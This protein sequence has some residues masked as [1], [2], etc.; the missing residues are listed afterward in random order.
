MSG[1]HNDAFLLY[2]FTKYI[3]QNGHTV[4]STPLWH[5][6]AMKA[7]SA[8][9]MFYCFL[10]RWCVTVFTDVEN[11]NN[12]LNT[13]AQDLSSVSSYSVYEPLSNDFRTVVQSSWKQKTHS[14]SVCDGILKQIQK[15]G[16]RAEITSDKLSVHLRLY[17]YTVYR[18]NI[19]RSTKRDFI[20]VSLQ[21]VMEILTLI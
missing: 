17:I 8:F 20:K 4:E 21:Q 5:K 11:K 19:V 15:T 3:L 12:C 16:N 7:M 2:Q 14:M 1:R 18:L 10:K 9:P 6:T 13:A